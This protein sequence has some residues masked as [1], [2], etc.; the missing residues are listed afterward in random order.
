MLTFIRFLAL[1]GAIGT[2]LFVGSGAILSLVGPAPLFM[3][4]ISMML[5]VWIVMN[6]LAEMC[7]YLPLKGISI[8]YFVSR[9]VEPSLAFADGKFRRTDEVK[10]KWYR[11]S[12]DFETGWNY[13][14]AYAILVP[15]EA[16]AGG[17]ILQYWTT[18]VN[19]GVWI[20]IILLVILILNIIA[21]AFFGEAEF[22]FASIKLITITGLIIVSIVIFFG[23]APDKGR[24]GFRY[25]EDVSIASWSRERKTDHCISEKR[26]VS[27]QSIL[28]ERIYRKLPGVLDCHRKGRLCLHYFP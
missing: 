12:A 4:Y 25:W 9:F 28:S 3:A 19:V 23:G 21:V 11:S 6:D 13:W 17:I 7:T 15:A 20:A 26:L 1:G 18:E 24:L 10:V 8:P 16:T 2:G 5:V 22:W 14:Y 27:F